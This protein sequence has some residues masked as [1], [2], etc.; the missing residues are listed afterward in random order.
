MAEIT[1]SWVIWMPPCC[2]LLQSVTTITTRPFPIVCLKHQSSTVPSISILFWYLLSGQ[3][4][5]LGCRELI[6]SFAMFFNQCT[7]VFFSAEKY[8]L[9]ISAGHVVT[10]T[11]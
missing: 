6:L 9:I 5:Y 3:R 2:G 1:V 7:V 10:I 8:S 4:W 11:L